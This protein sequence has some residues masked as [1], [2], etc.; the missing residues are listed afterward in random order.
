MIINSRFVGDSEIKVIDDYFSSEEICKFFKYAKI[1]PY[2][3]REYDNE[4]DEYPIFSVDFDPIKFQKEMEIGIKISAILESLCFDK[5]Y[6]LKR[7]YIN[8][9]HYGDVE[10]PHYDCLPEEKDITVLY[11]VNDFWDYTW[12]GETFFYLNHQPEFVVLPKPGRILIFPGN[13]EHM[14]SVPSRICKVSRLSLALKYS[15]IGN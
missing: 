6:C 14:G 3:R 10:F 7:V 8:M 12:S 5:S 11:Y 9:S 13:I 4:K 2:R 15:Y 1:L